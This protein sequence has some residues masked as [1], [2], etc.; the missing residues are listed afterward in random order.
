MSSASSL[1]SKPSSFLSGSNDQNS[2]SSAAEDIEQ[3]VNRYDVILASI[4]QSLE[5]I[6]A[7]RK[8]DKS[9]ARYSVVCQLSNSAQS[10]ASTS[11]ELDILTKRIDC[12]LSFQPPSFP[13]LDAS[14]ETSSISPQFSQATNP[15]SS[16]SPLADWRRAS[17]SS[18]LS[19]STLGTNRSSTNLASSAATSV[20]DVNNGNQ[21]HTINNRMNNQQQQEVLGA[22][23][24]RNS[25]EYLH[26]RVPTA[27][28]NT[29]VIP[30]PIIP[31]PRNSSEMPW[32]SNVSTTGVMPL[33]SNSGGGV[34]MLQYPANTDDGRSRANTVGAFGTGGACLRTNS[35]SSYNTS[36]TRPNSSYYPNTKNDAPQETGIKL[37]VALR[38]HLIK[39]PDVMPE[40]DIA[41]ALANLYETHNF[42][43]QRRLVW[44]TRYFVL[45]GH[46]LYRF[47][48]ENDNNSVL[49][50]MKLVPGSNVYVTDRFPGKRYCLEMSGAVCIMTD[51]TTQQQLE[52]VPTKRRSGGS[53]DSAL[54]WEKVI[55]FVQAPNSKSLSLWLNALKKA[56]V[57]AKYA[58]KQL[59]EPP[60]C[61]LPPMA[62]P[63]KYE[64]VM[65]R[66]SS[67]MSTAPT[68][69]STSAA[70][71]D[72]PRNE[73]IPE[74]EGL[75]SPNKMEM[76]NSVGRDEEDAELWRREIHK[77]TTLDV[78]QLDRLL[79]DSSK[80]S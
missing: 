79:S 8:L 71:E 42:F 53:I 13:N 65:R 1:V 17:F 50:I 44:K 57:R 24:A 66:Q 73:A 48:N 39:I 64:S 68:V 38:T 36:F 49:D 59:P 54:T 16:T 46:Y 61:G 62:P 37:E 4:R 10:S 35:L 29:R 58:V 51:E 45:Q 21:H 78:R 20:F 18:R 7:S 31:P 2:P 63:M 6:V 33:R 72:Q 70:L 52:Q 25:D 22:N 19:N 43:G 23:S 80:S 12:E 47:K 15:E 55:W 67:V 3:P 27:Q 9:P 77:V 26:C 34:G 75:L 41:G 69:V 60:N 5:Q 32:S 74:N 11:L 28:N 56:A 14:L 76:R 40:S 30:S